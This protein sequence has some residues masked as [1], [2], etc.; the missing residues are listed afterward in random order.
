VY[1]ASCLAIEHIRRNWN[2]IGIPFWAINQHFSRGFV[3]RRRKR[4]WIQGAFGAFKPARPR[5]PQTYLT[6]RRGARRSATP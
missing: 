1:G 5:A 4:A 6:V 3:A 2:H